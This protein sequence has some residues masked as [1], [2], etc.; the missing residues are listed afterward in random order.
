LGKSCGKIRKVISANAYELKVPFGKLWRGRTRNTAESIFEIQY[1]AAFGSGTTISGR[2]SPYTRTEFNPLMM[3]N[4]APARTTVDYA[5][6]SRHWQK[7]GSD[8]KR[9]TVKNISKNNEQDADPRFNETYVYFSYNAFNAG[10]NGVYDQP[11][12]R[13]CF[14]Q[15]GFQPSQKFSA[16]RLKKNS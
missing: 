2:T 5:T 9:S 6:F 16:F 3:Q 7:Y 8:A 13:I 1:S 11:I 15:S 12:V 10:T 14:P 4:T